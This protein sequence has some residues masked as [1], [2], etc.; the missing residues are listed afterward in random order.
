MRKVTLYEV[1]LLARTLLRMAEAD[2]P[3]AAA[4]ILQET[5]WAADCLRETGRAHPRF[6]DGSITARCLTLAPAPE[7]FCDDARVLR[8]LRASCDSLLIRSGS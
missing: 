4:R 5:R 6:G 1:G 2:W 3:A 7:P 8:A